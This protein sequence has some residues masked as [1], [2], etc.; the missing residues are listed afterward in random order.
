MTSLTSG[1]PAEVNEKQA[2]TSPH[3]KE[4]PWLA[5]RASEAVD[6][7]SLVGWGDGPGGGRLEGAHALGKVTL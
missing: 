4:A 1:V 6:R 5:E 7:L 3:Q 2:S